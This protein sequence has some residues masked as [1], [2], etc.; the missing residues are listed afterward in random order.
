MEIVPYETVSVLMFKLA[1][2]AVAGCLQVDIKTASSSCVWIGLTHE[3]ATIE[4]MLIPA[5]GALCKDLSLGDVESVLI[6]KPENAQKPVVWSG[7][8]AE[9]FDP[10]GVSVSDTVRYIDVKALAEEIKQWMSKK[11]EN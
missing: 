6:F 10:L 9:I 2:L 4:L 8:L 5:R 3:T 11:Q 7:E 1:Q